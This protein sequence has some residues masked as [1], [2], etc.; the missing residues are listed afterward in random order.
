MKI[1]V[2]AMGGD[3]APGE[4]VKG[5]VRAQRELGVEIVLVGRKEDVEACLKAENATDIPVIDAREVITMEDDPSTATRRKKDASMTVGLNQLRDGAADAR[6]LPQPATRN[7]IA[8]ASPP[9]PRAARSERKQSCG[10]VKPTT[11][12]R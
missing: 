12:L 1:I 7:A 6:S 11:S 8:S 9:G 2:D 3:N 10:F 5:A 4:I